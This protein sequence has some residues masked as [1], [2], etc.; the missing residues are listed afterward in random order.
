[1]SDDKQQRVAVKLMVGGTK[2]VKIANLEILKMPSPSNPLSDP[3]AS[4]RVGTGH[5]DQAGNPKVHGDGKVQQ[6]ETDEDDQDHEWDGGFYQNGNRQPSS[7]SVTAGRTLRS[8][9]RGTGRE[10]TPRGIDNVSHLGS[11]LNFNVLGRGEAR[12]HNAPT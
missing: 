9:G 6:S 1:M 12:S 7:S 5:G 4:S 11:H 3:R 2:N 8:L 10:V